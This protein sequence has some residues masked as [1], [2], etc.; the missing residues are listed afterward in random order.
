M[1]I[2]DEYASFVEVLASKEKKTRD[3]VMAGIYE[4]ILQGRQ[5][6]FLICLTM[7]KSDAKLIDTALRDNIPL[8]IVLG[9]SEKQT[10]ITAFGHADIPNRHYGSGDGVFTEP[11]IA[12]EPKLVQ[13]P[14]CDFDILKACRESLGGVTTQAPKI[15]E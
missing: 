2:I 10:Y 1:L 4:I 12:P 7:Q 5:L 3:P 11:S 14:Y 13:C 6:G 8:K 9:N 15:K